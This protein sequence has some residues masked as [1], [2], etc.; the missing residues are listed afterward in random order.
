MTGLNGRNRWTTRSINKVS[1]R[2]IELVTPRIFDLNQ[3]LFNYAINKVIVP[4]INAI[5]TMFSVIVPSTS[6]TKITKR[7][8]RWKKKKKLK[9]RKDDTIYFR[10]LDDDTIIKYLRENPIAFP[11]D[12]DKVISML[13]NEKY[14]DNRWKKKII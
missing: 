5:L 4:R 7:R 14:F 13:F 10:E 9:L 6:T 8:R 1:N 12:D 2:L 11:D 3:K